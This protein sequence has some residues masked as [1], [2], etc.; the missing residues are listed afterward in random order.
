M[1]SMIEVKRIKNLA[2]FR[3]FPGRIEARHYLDSP[4]YAEFS[5][6]VG[7]RSHSTSVLNLHDG[8]QPPDESQEL[9]LLDSDGD[10]LPGKLESYTRRMAETFI[11]R[12]PS[13]FMRRTLEF[14]WELSHQKKVRTW[15]GQ[16]GRAS[17]QYNLVEASFPFKS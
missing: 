14:A 1:L 5:A 8:V 13:I 12:E 3:Q 9:L 15:P 4:I 11:A 7:R 2:D 16:G 10:D 6:Q 17:Q